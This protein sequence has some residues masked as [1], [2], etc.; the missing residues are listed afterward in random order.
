VNDRLAAMGDEELG[1]SIAVA[2]EALDWP[3]TPDVAPSVVES[4]RDARRTG[5]THLPLG[6]P[7]RRRTV[8]LIAAA[9][10]LLS[11]AAVGAAKFV[12]DLGAVEVVRVPGTPSASATIDPADLGTPVSLEQAGQI[13][14]FE[15]LVPSA[16]GS[17]DRVWVDEAVVGFDQPE[18]TVRIVMAWRPGV[19]LPRIPGS[20]WGALVLEFGGEADVASKMIYAE[21]GRVR[22]VTVH[23]RDGYWITG[24]HGLRLLTRSGLRTFRIR[25]NVLVWNE[26]PGLVLRIETAL[27]ATSAIRIGNRFG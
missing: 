7:H 5:I 8:W 6:L 4:I 9:I 25:G 13:A 21:T 17:P 18:R 15:P 1:R 27:S 23:G 3:P 12:I 19:G 16:L 26:R 20:A 14:G 2:L 24:E 11:A 10:L 22:G